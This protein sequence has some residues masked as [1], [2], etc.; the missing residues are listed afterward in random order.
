MYVDVLWIIISD[1]GST[2]ASSTTNQKT[3]TPAR[4]FL[5]LKRPEETLLSEGDLRKQQD[6]AQH[7]ACFIFAELD[8]REGRSAGWRRGTPAS[9]SWLKQ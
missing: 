5:F 9:L 4:G 1:A 6:H 3:S 7:G 8:L 2:P